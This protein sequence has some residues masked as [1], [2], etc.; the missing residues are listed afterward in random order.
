MATFSYEELE[1][2]YNPYTKQI[3][4][5]DVT[6]KELEQ[7]RADIEI[8]KDNIDLK[9]SSDEILS[10][11]NLST[12]WVYIK[13]DRIQLDWD[14]NVQWTFTLGMVNWSLDDIADWSIYKKVTS[15][16]KTWASRWYN[17]LNSSNRY[18]NWLSSSDMSS[19]SLPSTWVVMWSTWII[20]R[21]SWT[22]TFELNASTWDATF[23][24]EISAES[25]FINWQLSV[26]TWGWIAA[27]NYNWTTWWLLDNDWLFIW[28]DKEIAVQPWGSIWVW[29]YWPGPKVIIEDWW[30]SLYD[31]PLATPAV[32][33]ST[34][35]WELLVNWQPVW[36]WGWTYGRD[37]DGYFKL[38]VGTNM[39]N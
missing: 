9:V 25:W 19:P 39:Y 12:E 13:W 23:K 28:N 16:E 20:W 30:V 36:S 3:E 33:S 32:L 5:I 18:Q 14:V 22:T 4:Q 15:S 2:R 21:K 34:F 38:P 8:N 7:F 17:A 29:V 1:H 35:A 31:A 26:W 27:N 11:I 24:W 10:Q 6:D 37:N